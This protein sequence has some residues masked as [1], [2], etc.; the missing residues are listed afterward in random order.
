[1][2]SQKK[3]GYLIQFQSSS[4]SRTIRTAETLYTTR[5]LKFREECRKS[6]LTA[7]DLK[8]GSGFPMLDA[9][10]AFLCTGS[11]YG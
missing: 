5:D 4:W 11:V 7:M 1:M 2:I 8:T 3:N 9:G 6:L 10:L